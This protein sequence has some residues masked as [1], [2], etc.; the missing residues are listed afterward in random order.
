MT[1]EEIRQLLLDTK[2]IAVVGLSANLDRAS[3]QVAWYLHH[4]GYRLFGVNPACPEQELFEG[5]PWW[6]PRRDPRADRH[7]RRV[8][9][10]RV[11]PRRG[12]SRRRRRR[13]ALGSSSASATTRPARSPRKRVWPTSRTAASR[14]TTRDCWVVAGP[15]GGP[16]DPVRLPPLRSW[17]TRRSSWRAVLRKG[18]PS[19]KSVTYRRGA[20]WSRRATATAD[21]RSTQ[22]SATVSCWLP[23]TVLY[24][25]S[26]LPRSRR[27]RPAVAAASAM[28]RCSISPGEY[29]AR[30]T[31]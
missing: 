7:R 20:C 9:P 1:D 12:P 5:C 11:H 2:V 19:T 14:S 8:P 16:P 17:P 13:R 22:P 21:G 29:L 6:P 15:P 10:P 30:A 23:S 3:N 25:W 31:S 4:Q 28:N 24:S 18:R 27:R 26:P